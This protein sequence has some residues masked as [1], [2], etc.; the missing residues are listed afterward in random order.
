M[1]CMTLCFSVVYLSIAAR[2]WQSETFALPIMAGMHGWPFPPLASLSPPSSPSDLAQPPPLCARLFALTHSD[3]LLMES[4]TFWCQAFKTTF[5]ETFSS[6]AEENSQSRLFAHPLPPP[7]RLSSGSIFFFWRGSLYNHYRFP[8]ICAGRDNSTSIPGF[9]SLFIFFKGETTQIM[10]GVL[11]WQPPDRR[12][13]RTSFC[14]LKTQ[15]YRFHTLFTPHDYLS[16][17]CNYPSRWLMECLRGW[18]G[19]QFGINPEDLP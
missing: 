10:E 14:R 4:L 9:C 12:C 18:V 19:E 8:L 16:I 3:Y 17:T 5:L 15:S 7:A 13:C 11:G 6:L 2:V 1:C